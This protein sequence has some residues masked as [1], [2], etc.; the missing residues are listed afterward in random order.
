MKAVA[1]EKI[2][3]ACAVVLLCSAGI[4]AGLSLILL[5]PPQEKARFM[6]GLADMHGHMA[7]VAK[8][9][10][11]RVRHFQD[12]EKSLLLGLR[13]T[14]FDYALW[15]KISAY[16]ST[17]GQVRK[18]SESRRIMERLAPADDLASPASGTDP[19]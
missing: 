10:D 1:P 15:Q 11:E 17:S 14:P 18:A 2:Y 4:V 8:S 13:Q 7:S 9:E 19:R 5:R 12:M 3:A 6:I 16:Y